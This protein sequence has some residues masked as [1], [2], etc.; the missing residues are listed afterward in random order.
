[1][2][3]RD[4]GEPVDNIVREKLSHIYCS[5]FEGGLSQLSDIYDIHFAGYHGRSLMKS[6]YLMDNDSFKTFTNN[7][8]LGDRTQIT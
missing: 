6:I 7:G 3:M 8:K 1:M 4:Q 2:H 5:I